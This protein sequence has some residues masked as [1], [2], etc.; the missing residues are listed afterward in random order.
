MSRAYF[1]GGAPRSGKTTA[2]LKLIQKYPILAASTDAIRHTIRGVTSEQAQPDLFKSE[3]GPFASDKNVAAMRSD[4]WKVIA[5]QN[6]ESEVV[7]RSVVDF[8]E[9]NIEDGKEVAV[10]GVAVLPHNFKTKLKF[11]YKAVFVVNL[12]DQTEVILKHAH[13]NEFDWLHKYSDEVIRAFCVFNREL[14]KYYFEEAKKYSLP[15]VQVDNENFN[16]AID[17]AVSL[18]I[19][20]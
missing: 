5:H 8:V 18:L 14:N 7:W 3:R 2:L 20:N 9:G 19:G 12:T 15:I 13:E 10:E 16:A 1:I 4:P 17:E 6:A 11:D